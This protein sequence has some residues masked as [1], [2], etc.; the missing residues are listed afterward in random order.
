MIKKNLT[1]IFVV[2]ASILYFLVFSY[3]S[4]L[5]HN[6]FFSGYDLSNFDH[7]LWNTVHGKF[8][9]LTVDDKFVSRLSVHADFILIPLS[10]LYFVWQDI[11]FILI[12]Q[13]FALAIS[14]VPLFLLSKKIFKKEIPGVFLLAAFLLNPAIQWAN[15]YD[16]HPV[17]LAIP[18]VLFAIYFLE[19]KKKLSALIFLFIAVLT[20]ENVALL[21]FCLGIWLFFVKKEKK[22]GF[23]ISFLSLSYFVFIVF[24]AMRLASGNAQANVVNLYSFSNEVKKEY[25]TDSR[26]QIYSSR[27]FTDGISLLYYK[28]LLKLFFV[29]PFF[30]PQFSFVALPEILI[31]VLSS[32]SVMS[33]IYQHYSALLSALLYVSSIYGILMLKKLFKRYVKF[34]IVNVCSFV[35]FLLSFWQFF[36]LS[37]LPFNPATD[38]LIFSKTKE[39]QNFSKF[40]ERVPKNASVS[41]SS[42]I[43]PHLTHREEVY[44]LPNKIESSDFV[45]F[46]LHRRLFFDHSEKTF[47]KNLLKK[48][49]KD[50]NY[51]LVFQDGDFYA[52]RKKGVKLLN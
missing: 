42:A 16:F 24:F 52:F 8:F 2:V 48:L 18:F 7:T 40:L 5:R 51:E 12:L 27:L 31:N 11:R 10:L 34:E 6:N 28:Q 3:F 13:S 46:T 36:K 41:S 29:F 20:K 44:V 21:N 9:Q 23:W 25:G 45:L 32:N 38:A 14:V 4:I 43:R 35:L 47:E 49:K 15:L 1:L 33:G 39:A 30:A 17:L 50:K 37:P 22:T 26:I 19:I